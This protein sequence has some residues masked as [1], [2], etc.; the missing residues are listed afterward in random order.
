MDADRFLRLRS[1]VDQALELTRAERDEFVRNACTDD[2]ELLAEARALLVHDA[3]GRIRSHRCARGQIRAAATNALGG[4]ALPGTIGPYRIVAKL[5]EGGMGVVYR[6]EQTGALERSVALK[7][8]RAG[9][10]SERVV[11]RFAGERLT[12]ARMDHPN[13]ARVFDAGATADGRPWFAMEL[14]AG[15]PPDHVVRR[16]SAG[17]PASACVCSWRSAAASSTPTRRASSTATSSR[18]TC[19]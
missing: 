11:A 10:S 1:V 5:G 8:I 16:P 7:L 6:A 18:R 15:Q 9:W 13:I 17:H 14:V 2:P 12:L 3:A 4:D 19:W